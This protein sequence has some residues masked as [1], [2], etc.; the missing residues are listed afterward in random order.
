LLG[1]VNFT[2]IMMETF[3]KFLRCGENVPID[4]NILSLYRLNGQEQNSLPG[5]MAFAPP[6]KAARGRER[7]PLFV[8]LLLNGNTPFSAAEYD[9]LAGDAAAAFHGMHGAL[10][11]A[12]R[13]A[14]EAVN[15]ALLER[16]LS[17][18]G[19]G[20]YAI[21]WLT[22]AVLRESQLTILQ[23]GPTHVLSFSGGVTRHLYDPA[24]SG[25]GLGLSQG[26]SQF[27]SQI[28]LQ[29]G[30]RL[31][32]C[33]TRSV[34]PAWENVLGSDRGLPALESTRKR[35]LALV[36]GDVSGALIQATEGTG[37]ML[38]SRS[39]GTPPPPPPKPVDVSP[40]VDSAPAFI[41]S[42]PA[43]RDVARNVSTSNVSTSNVSTSNVS[44]SN[45]STSNVST[46][47]HVVGQPSA[48][49]IPPEP[50]QSV[51]TLHA[52]SL[53]VEQLASAAMARQF[54]PSIPRAKP[55]EPELESIP[56]ADEE[57]EPE[58]EAVDTTSAAP[59]RSPEEI[60][61]RRAEGNRQA[62]RAAVSGIQAWR[63]VT[64]QA[65]ARLRKFLPNLLPGGESD[66]TLPVPAMAF[67]SILV[68]LLVVTIAIVVY[69][70]FGV[71][72]QYDMYITQAQTLRSQ[73]MNETDPVRRREAWNNVLQR[74][75]LAEKYNVTGDTQSMRQEAQAQLDALLGV[76]RLHFIPI[77]SAG[78]GAEI[79]RMAASDT[80]LFMLDAVKGNILRAAVT[81]RGYDLDAAFDCRPGVYGNITVGPLVD[82]LILPKSN[83][84]N[85][86]TLGVDAAG[87]LLYCAPGQTPRALT[88]TPPGTNWGRVVAVALD[89]NK[90]YVLDAPARAVWIY[91]GRQ[92]AATQEEMD[93]FED[94]PYIFFSIQIP[95]IQ[96]AI[97]IAVSGDE[98]YLLHA[99]GR[100]T[101]CMYSRI[102]DVPTRCDSPV[103][104]LNRFPAYGDTDVFSLAHFTQMTLTGMPDSTLF[105]LDADGQSVYRLSSRG[106]ELQGIL[107]AASGAL[108]SGQL[109]ALAASPSHI[110]YLARGDQVYVTNDAP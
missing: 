101:Y 47:A 107:G 45:V 17:T 2:S 7:E 29:P 77:F 51:E 98:L 94:A 11:S 92:D 5:L 10:T 24:L 110:L 72:S 36:E 12:L 60:A 20:Q 86:S 42:P 58:F 4:L 84:L 33:P 53:Q 27:F 97:D 69:M 52:T 46:G 40:A 35:M 37:D 103:K 108:P 90:L 28:Q 1:G 57:T 62:A 73:A 55:N 74:V 14:A 68:P 82:L 31:L 99:D 32:V 81:G 100:L 48:Y 76:S 85:S 23:C 22:L 13:A 3:R 38:L 39:D 61:L 56:E 49:A 43:R 63:R 106:F 95:E 71:S 75:A 83:M 44:T 67:I 26:I 87:N 15:R 25:K 34:P 78:A 9:K 105:L 59:R 41:P 89:S 65:G 80:D 66:I 91:N 50:A 6:R 54:P 79:S 64:E 70:R 30:D 104:L 19:R 8:S 96:D 93:T 18:T 102:D 88:L 109:G 21:G 16:N